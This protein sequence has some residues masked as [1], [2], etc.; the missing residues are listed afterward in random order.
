[1]ARGE[2]VTNFLELLLSAGGR[3]SLAAAA[4]I[5]RLTRAASASFKPR[6][7]IRRPPES[8]LANN[9]FRRDIGL[10]PVDSRGWRL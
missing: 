6:R 10:P 2:L 5:D 8:L 9:H 3:A 1:M 4:I 7:R